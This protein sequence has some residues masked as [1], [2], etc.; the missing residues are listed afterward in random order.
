MNCYIPITTVGELK[1]FI[2]EMPDKTLIF[3]KDLDIKC[4]HFSCVENIEVASGN[5]WFRGYDIDSRKIENR[6]FFSLFVR[7]IKR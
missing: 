1:K 7:P 6:E 4:S 2:A 3:I 5:Q